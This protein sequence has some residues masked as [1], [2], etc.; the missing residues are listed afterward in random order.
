MFCLLYCDTEVGECWDCRSLFY[1]VEIHSVSG[2][3]NS[4][5]HT[6]SKSA[7]ST[8][9]LYKTWILCHTLV[10]WYYFFF[11]AM[12]T[13]MVSRN[14]V[15]YFFFEKPEINIKN[16]ETSLNKYNYFLYCTKSSEY[17]YYSKKQMIASQKDLNWQIQ[18]VFLEANAIFLR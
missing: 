4:G 18:W 15:I 5:H 10:R 6:C 11:S 2:D 1:I 12:S 16:N 9:H 7:I 13:F 3:L 14:P 17:F 8:K